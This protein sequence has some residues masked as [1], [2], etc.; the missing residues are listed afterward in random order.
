MVVVDLDTDTAPAPPVQALTNGLVPMEEVEG[1]QQ[2]CYE[3][4]YYTTNLKCPTCPNMLCD[5]DDA[6]GDGCEHCGGWFCRE[7]LRKCAVCA[8]DDYLYM[9]KLCIP[10]ACKTCDTAL[11]PAH[12]GEASPTDYQLIVNSLAWSA[13]QRVMVC[14]R[15][16]TP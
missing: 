6:C 15:M 16:T 3:H 2:P 12:L 9:C 11:C 4:P 13:A 1:E 14:G 8:S 7:C 10:Q 5:G